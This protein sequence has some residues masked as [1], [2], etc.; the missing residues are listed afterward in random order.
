M[1]E[2]LLTVRGTL[3]LALALIFASGLAPGSVASQELKPSPMPVGV[4]MLFAS[5]AYAI[6]GRNAREILGQLRA[7]GPSGRWA[8]FPY[9]YTWSYRTERVLRLNGQPSDRCRIT[10]F[11]IEITLTAAYPRWN[12]PTDPDPELVAAWDDF[13]AQLE[14]VWDQ[15]QADVAGRAREAVSSVRRFEESCAFMR[16]RIEETV[17]AAFASPDP[18]TA[19]EP[20]LGLR[21]PP[22]AYRHLMAPPR[23]PVDSID[24]PPAGSGG[25]GAPRERPVPPPPAVRTAGSI[26]LAVQMDL[27]SA[28]GFVI[29]LH[30]RDQLQFREAFGVTAPGAD[31]E[32]TPDAPMAF[33]SFTEILIASLASALADDGTVDL[34]APIRTY[35]PDLPDGIGGTTL[36]QLLTHTGGLDNTLMPDT[37]SWSRVMDDLRDNALFTAPG[38]IFSYSRFSYPLA[39]RVLEAATGTPLEE[40]VQTRLLRPLGLESTTLGPRNADD[41]RD[42]LPSTHTTATDLTAFWTA[43]LDGRITGAGPEQLA[44]ARSASTPDDGP[45][46]QAGFWYDRIND[47]PR[48]SLMC[49]SSLTGHSG[50]FQVYPDT[51]TILVFLARYDGGDEDAA[52]TPPSPT[53]WPRE[54]VRFVLSRMA[55]ALQLGNDV[56]PR[57]TL[58]G[59]GQTAAAPRRCAEPAVSEYRVDDFG[60]R[61]PTGDWA[62]RYVNGEWFFDLVD[63]D[64]ELASPIDTGRE[65]YSIRHYG[66]D[67]YFADMG[68]ESG[69]PV[70]FP[71]RLV[72]DEAGRRYVVLGERAYL[73][74]SDRPTR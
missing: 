72:L 59:G 68:L 14:A 18:R 34:D 9:T 21:W 31:A 2:K 40:A 45:V 10:D 50:G 74:E 71:L 67:V 66:A 4:D 35:R 1:E 55:E 17:V 12:R 32:M 37:A 23:Q 57:S 63:R 5:D 11:D 46:F 6:A 27:G 29:D 26:D 69:P 28:T 43:W 15:F 44:D 51:R 22:E 48:V 41:A 7:R 53:R 47:V 16:Q 52:R 25:A 56:Y 62:G 13:T 38:A 19:D 64:G 20:R 58:T 70:G 30:H 24:T 33:P 49:G 39:V 61:V 65:P 42:G 3:A 8:Q 73:H 54:S 36:S 60:P